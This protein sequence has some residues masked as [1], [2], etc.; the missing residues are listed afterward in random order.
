MKK[1]K[2][3]LL[4]SSGLTG[5]HLLRLLLESGMYEEVRIFVRRDPGL[6][7]PGLKITE[8]SFD[9]M[10]MYENFFTV[11]DIFCCLGTTIKQAG[12]KKAFRTVDHDYVLRAAYLG[13]DMGACRFFVITAMGADPKSLIFYNRIKGQVEEDLRLV[14]FRAIHVF[15]PSLLLGK[16]SEK[17]AGEKLAA[18]LFGVFGFAFTGPLRR[19]RAI[20]AN[21]VAAAMVRS[22]SVDSKGFHVYESHMI[23]EMAQCAD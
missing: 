13:R 3:L 17:R 11:D 5:G 18:A 22:A 12:T 19:Y 10:E 6:I 14:P 8:G 1:R 15:R 7:H 4:G 21:T 2:A 23:H 16:R 9:R 20:P